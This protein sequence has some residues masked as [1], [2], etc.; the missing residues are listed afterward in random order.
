MRPDNLLPHPEGGRF[1]EVFRSPRKVLADN[2]RARDAL[3]HIY[4][5]LS[6]GEV[7]RFHRVG[8]DE[9]WS[10]YCG[11]GLRLY[12]WDGRGDEI[13]C[14]ELSRNEERFCHVVPA[15]YWQAAEVIAAPEA[16]VGCS[17]GPGFDFADFELI[18]PEGPEAQRLRKMDP[19]LERFIRPATDG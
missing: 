12:Q 15:G 9:V 10:L 2:G 4:F 16:L 18:D 8:S 17:V 11:R 14:V 7:S 13:D 3:T 19:E 6:P 1:Q 5:E